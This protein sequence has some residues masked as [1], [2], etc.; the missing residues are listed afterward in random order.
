MV[1]HFYCC[2]C[3]IFSTRP[4]HRRYFEYS[5]LSHYIVI[6][7]QSDC[8]CYYR[9]LCSRIRTKRTS[10][11]TGWLAILC[12]DALTLSRNPHAQ[13]IK[14]LRV[15]RVFRVIRLATRSMLTRLLLSSLITSVSGVGYVILIVSGTTCS[16]QFHGPQ[17][18]THH[19]S[20]IFSALMH[21]ND[22]SIGD[23][24]CHCRHAIISRKVSS[25]YSQWLSFRRIERPGKCMFLMHND[26]IPVPPTK[27]HSAACAHHSRMQ[28]IFLVVLM[29]IG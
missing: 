21:T 6:H 18:D 14:L 16:D 15:M 28:A 12:S 4:T 27:L 29:G 23:R 22:N 19:C 26:R 11:A 2:A 24:L 25:L 13:I 7:H 5:W 9:Q 20:N 3:S 1:F 17:D 8:G 10:I